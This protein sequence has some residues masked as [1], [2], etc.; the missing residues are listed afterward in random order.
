MQEYELE[1]QRLK[2]GSY[3]SRFTSKLIVV[4]GNRKHWGSNI[5]GRCLISFMI[6]PSL[7][8]SPHPRMMTLQWLLWRLCQ[9]LRCMIRTFEM[10]GMASRFLDFTHFF[11]WGCISISKDHLIYGYFP[12]ATE[13]EVEKS[14]SKPKR[15]VRSKACRNTPEKTSDPSPTPST[16]AP[17]SGNPREL[18]R[19][20]GKTADPDK[21]RVIESLRE[22]G[23]GLLGAI[24]KPNV[25]IHV[26]SV[27]PKLC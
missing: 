17:P 10:L 20:K 11:I 18:K 27:S 7:R 5:G 25:P 2:D 6:L 19:V 8:S 4:L 26:Q 14:L 1:I 9:I 12:E 22:V 3:D 16:P 13:E 23:V 21:D 24:Q 15:R